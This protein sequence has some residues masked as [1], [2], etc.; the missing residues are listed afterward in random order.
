VLQIL[1][2]YSF[3]DIGAYG[4]QSDGGTYSAST[5]YHFL[6]DFESTI[7]KPAS[8]EGRGTEIPFVVLGD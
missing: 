7:L 5:L 1:K 8:F 4:K 2:A 3:L 6:E